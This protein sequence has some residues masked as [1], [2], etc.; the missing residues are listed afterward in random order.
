MS[1]LPSTRRAVVSFDHPGLFMVR[2]ERRSAM[3]AAAKT[4]EPLGRPPERARVAPT[5]RQRGG[6]HRYCSGCAHETE[7]VAWAGDGRGGVRSIRWPAADPASGSTICLSCGQWR[8]ATSQPSLPAWSRWPR[9]LIAIRDLEITTDSA[10]APADWVSETAA[11]NEGMPPKRELP[12]GRRSA[13]V[14]RVPA[15]ARS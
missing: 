8:A 14:R 15:R 5:D 2:L 6:L 3:P 9:K 12:T 10:R 4:L 1:V 13:R 11:E 7:H